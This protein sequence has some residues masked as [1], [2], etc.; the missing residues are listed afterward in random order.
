MSFLCGFCKDEKQQVCQSVRFSISNSYGAYKELD[1]L[2]SFGQKKSAI[3]FRTIW[4][5][6]VLQNENTIT[7]FTLVASSLLKGTSCD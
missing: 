6:A 7:D 4:P 3:F 5:Q 1:V 2:G